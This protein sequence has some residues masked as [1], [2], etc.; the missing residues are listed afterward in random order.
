[1]KR[2]VLLILVGL[3][4]IVAVPSADALKVTHWFLPDVP[5]KSVSLFGG[6]KT[7]HY[8]VVIFKYENDGSK[9]VNIT[10][11]YTLVA[12]MKQS[13]KVQMEPESAMLLKGELEKK[14]KIKD[15]T[16]WVGEIYPG[17]LKY[18]IVVFKKLP[19]AT[20]KFTVY[21]KGIY[22]YDEVLVIKYENKAGK[23]K[24]MS[25]RIEKE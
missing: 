15:E 6:D 14:Y 23:W 2:F 10:D 18:R 19:G 1:M 20:K 13:Q 11:R 25:E 5:Y 22:G 4:G 7:E 17:V 8:S 16:M 3:L 24:K 12:E 9:V 21:C